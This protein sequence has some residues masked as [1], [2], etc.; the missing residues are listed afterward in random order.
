MGPVPAAEQ[1]GMLAGLFLWQVFT[2]Q[3]VD[4][5]FNLPLRLSGNIGQDQSLIID[6]IDLFFSENFEMC[7]RDRGS[8]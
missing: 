8:P 1:S 5:I 4:S 2:Q 3:T 6:P 7:I